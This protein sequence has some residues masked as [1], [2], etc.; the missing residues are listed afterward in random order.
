MSRLVNSAFG[1]VCLG[2]GEP[3]RYY[4]LRL[5]GWRRVGDR[6]VEGAPDVRLAA[7]RMDHADQ[8]LHADLVERGG[9]AF[10]EQLSTD[11]HRFV[12]TPAMFEDDG[13]SCAQERGGLV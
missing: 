13:S 9:R 1:Q 12:P 11:R 8:G 4:V 2:P 7:A 5:A 6:A 3:G 10:L